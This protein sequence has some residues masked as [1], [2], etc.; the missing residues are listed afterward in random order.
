MRKIKW[1]IRAFLQDCPEKG[2]YFFMLIMTLWR[3][4]IVLYLKI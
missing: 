2:K 3:H 1:I 4:K